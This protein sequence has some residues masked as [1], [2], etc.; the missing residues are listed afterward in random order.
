MGMDAIPYLRLVLFVCMGTGCSSQH[1][2]GLKSTQWFPDG[3]LMTDLHADVAIIGSGFGGTLTALILRKIGLRPVVIERGTH[4]RLVLGESSTPVADLVLQQL[5]RKYYLPRIAPLAEYGTWQR[6]YPDLPCGL[7]RGF[8][9]FRHSPGEHF[10]PRENHANELLVAASRGDD[11]SDAHWFRP[12]FDAF[13][14]QEV[15]AAGI[16]YFDRT[17]IV[18]LIDGEPWTVT[19][20]RRG[21][22]LRLTAGFII[23]ATGEAGFLARRLGIPTTPEGMLTNSRCV[24]GHFT[25]VKR[26]ADV[27]SSRV[28]CAHRETD[29]RNPPYWSDH[30]F[31]CDDAAVHHIFDGGWMYVLRFN[32]GVTSAGFLLDA[33]RHPLDQAVAA[34]TEW[35]QWLDRYPS[36]AEQFAGTEPTG[37]CGSIR[38]TPRLQRLARRCVGPNWAMLPLAAYSLDALH[39]S[40]NAHTLCGIERLVRILENGL[41]TDRLYPE[42]LKYQRTLRAEIGLVDTIVHGCYSAFQDF[43]LLA[44]FAMF[45]FA[46]ATTS[47]HARRT[48]THR[49]EHAFLLAHDSEFVARVQECYN[50]LVNA[51]VDPM[52]FRDHVARV[53]EPYNI[54]GLCDPAKRNMYPFAG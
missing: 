38:R 6:E 49:P 9:Y 35:R 27:I 32:N 25:G 11:D 44:S 31:P 10:V 4:P 48:G 16:P 41:G 40:G 13:L 15:Q 21:E 36:I 8:S 5:C 17:E 54:A 24:Y 23:D 52:E 12:S 29:G 43:E 2:R 45:Y 20:D 7:K 53:L 28:G 46:A 50:R 3:S 1:A 37:L 42:L 51:T 33:A 34:E 19:A 39:S 26:W 47:E 30:P 14:V 22:H 18:D